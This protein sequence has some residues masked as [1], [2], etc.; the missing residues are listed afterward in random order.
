MK[1]ELE[2]QAELIPTIKAAF[3][4][5]VA[6][7]VRIS[8]RLRSGTPDITTTACK[9]TSWE[10][11]KVAKPNVD[12]RGKTKGVQHATCKK[13]AKAGWCWYII[14][15]EISKIDLSLGVKHRLNADYD[16]EYMTYIV[17]PEDLKADGTFDHV[18]KF[19]GIDH[20]G[21]ALWIRKIHEA[22]SLV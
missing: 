13:L 11:V 20:V 1:S 18:A 4:G 16:K 19:E 22:G 9:M 21:V 6:E 14:Y 5:R 8:D 3:R 2:L 17:H 12:M 15:Q 10:E 7:V